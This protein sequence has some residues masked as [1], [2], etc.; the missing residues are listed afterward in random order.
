MI[1]LIFVLNLI[2]NPLNYII[3][4][5]FFIIGLFLIGINYK[6]LKKENFSFTFKNNIQWL[7]WLILIIISIFTL[8]NTF[9]FFNLEKAEYSKIIKDIG[10]NGIL[11]FKKTPKVV[12]VNRGVVL[13]WFGAGYR[14]WNNSIE[15]YNPKILNQRVLNHELVHYNISQLNLIKQIKIIKDLTNIKK[16]IRQLDCKKYKENNKKYC[17]SLKTRE[18]FI[19]E[20]YK[21]PLKLSKIAYIVPFFSGGLEEYLAYYV[22]DY[23]WLSNNYN[24]DNK[25]L[26]KV[27]QSFQNILKLILKKDN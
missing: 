9:F 26:K 10:D 20:K 14:L 21:Y 12:F 3:S 1:N 15:I 27:H 17:K 16:T 23:W 6:K 24:I 13:E 7:T 11:N 18:K 22:S 8:S 2:L 4:C 19:K 5:L 25:D